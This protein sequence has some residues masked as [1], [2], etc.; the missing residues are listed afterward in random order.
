MDVD[1]LVAIE[2]DD[3]PLLAAT[4]AIAV[5]SLAV[6]LFD[7]E[8]NLLV[9]PL[10]V[11]GTLAFV[12]LTLQRVTTYDPQVTVSAAAMVLGSVLVA[13]DIGVFF[14]FD[15]PLGAALFLFGAIGLRGYLDE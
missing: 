15:G 4:A 7:A 11:G 9:I 2:S 8:G 14:D 10:L 6:I 13:F 12:W 1:G 5:G 3:V